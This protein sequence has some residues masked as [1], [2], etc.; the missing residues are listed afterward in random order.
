[1]QNDFRILVQKNSYGPG[2]YIGLIVNNVK[3]CH[4]VVLNRHDFFTRLV[5]IIESSGVENCFSESEKQV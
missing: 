2:V 3:V 4:F 1:M 5:E